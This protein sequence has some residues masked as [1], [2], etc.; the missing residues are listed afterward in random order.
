[1][2]CSAGEKMSCDA[3]DCTATAAASS[4]ASAVPTMPTIMALRS[5][6]RPAYA[7]LDGCCAN[8]VIQQNLI[9][10]PKLGHLDHFKLQICRRA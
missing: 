4:T 6:M 2:S 9:T 3:P 8:Y 7:F 5:A 1:M 10:W